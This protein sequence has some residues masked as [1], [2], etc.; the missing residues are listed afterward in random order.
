MTHRVIVSLAAALAICFWVLGWLD[1]QLFA[2]HFY[3]SLIY[4][5]IVAL[6]LLWKDRWAYMLGMLGPAAWSVLILI[7]AV[8]ALVSFALGESPGIL[9]TAL[10]IFWLRQPSLA[11]GIVEVI[12]LGLSISMIPVCLKRWT[13]IPTARLQVRSTFLVCLAAVAV[14]YGVLIIWLLRWQPAAA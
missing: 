13:S 9:R 4:L 11:A 6:L 14:Y 5:A 8:G 3:E 2:V 10:L 1:R 12:A 7:P